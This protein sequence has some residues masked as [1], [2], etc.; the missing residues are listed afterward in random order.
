MKT[1]FVAPLCGLLLGLVPSA[2]AAPAKKPADSGHFAVSHRIPIGGEGGWDYVTVDAPRHR[3]FLSHSTRVEVVDAATDSVVGVIQD[4]PGV[5]GI[6]LASDLGRGFTSN[7]RD[8]SVSVFDYA[9]LAPIARIKL[10]ARNPDAIAYDAASQRVFTF[11]GGSGNA[12]AIDAK[13]NA[14]IGNIPL[15]GKP[16]FAVTDGKGLLFVNNED[17]SQVVVLDTRTLQVKSKWRLGEGEEPSGL[18]IDRAHGRLFS[19]CGNQKMVILDSSTGAV[20]ATLP[21][22]S[23]VDAAAFDAK[24][25]LAFASNGEG[26]L[27]VVRE[28]GPN[29]FSVLENATTERGARTMALDETS[30]KAYLPTADFGPPPAPTADRPHPRPSIVPGSFRVLVVS[31]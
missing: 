13:T 10:D 15:G 16:E 7:G 11:N 24:R 14:V 2:Q 21:I 28:D 8:S 18:A 30:G 29:K 12:T 3:L 26:T 31:R 9:T 25:G 6:A 1:R 17:S 27:T 20:V 23:G 19:V 4:T 22:G 5:H